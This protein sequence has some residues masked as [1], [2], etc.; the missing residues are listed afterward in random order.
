MRQPIGQVT[1]EECRAIYRLHERLSSLRELLLCLDPEADAA[2]IGRVNV[3]RERTQARF[4]AWWTD[5][6][7]KYSWPPSSYEIDFESANI[8]TH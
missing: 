5:M 6:A 1:P 7:A 3:D 8:Y 4:D 2:L